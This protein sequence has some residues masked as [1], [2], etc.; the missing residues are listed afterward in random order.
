[1]QSFYLVITTEKL[2]LYDIMNCEWQYFEGNPYLKYSMQMIRND[3]KILLEYMFDYYNMTIDSSELE[4]VVIK[5]A[6]AIRSQLILEALNG[7]VKDT[8]EIDNVIQ[9][10]IAKLA[11]DRMLY[12][13]DFGVNYDGLNYK[14]QSNKLMQREFNL[15]GYT[16]NEE[17]IINCIV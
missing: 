16:I 3:V 11:D 12:I 9:K 14:Y 7:F 2:F 1:M 10:I 15:L 4:F 6:D 17:D 8:I 5:H 13:D